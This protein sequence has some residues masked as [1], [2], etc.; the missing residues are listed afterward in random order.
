MRTIGAHLHITAALSA[1]VVVSACTYAPE[2]EI[3]SGTADEV[4]IKAAPSTNP[5]PLAVE[6]CAKY[7]KEARLRGSEQ[8]GG[9]EMVAYMVMR[10][11]TRIYYFDCVR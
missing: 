2:P 7:D 1:I 9:G 10:S 6:H 11:A 4:A 8:V 5:G 3:V